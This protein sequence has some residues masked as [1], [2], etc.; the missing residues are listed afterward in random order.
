MAGAVS[1]ERGEYEVAAGSIPTAAS[2]TLLTSMRKMTSGQGLEPEQVW[3]DPDLAAS[4]YGT[5]P[6]TV[7]RS[8][9]PTASPPA[10][11]AR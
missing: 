11:P 1:S 10:R 5:D 8:G 6:A 4:P 3:E 2:A 7:A 9:S